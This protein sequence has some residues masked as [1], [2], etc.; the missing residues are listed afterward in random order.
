MPDAQVE[1]FCHM[2][3]CTLGGIWLG[4]SHDGVPLLVAT[5]GAIAAFGHGGRRL[6]PNLVVGGVKGLEERSWQ[7]RCLRIG[8][9]LIGLEDLRGRCVMT[10]FDPDTLDQNRNVLI[11]IVRRFGG[12]LAL[13][14]FV[15]RGG[16]VQEG[17]GVEL[18]PTD[19]RP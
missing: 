19:R 6:R 8:S 9:V 14:A 11:D 15:I 7:G 5:D 1:K 3:Q 12:K 10:T 16:T 17:D 18:L 4:S 13:N 2:N